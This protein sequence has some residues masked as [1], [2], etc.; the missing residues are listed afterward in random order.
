MVGSSQRLIKVRDLLEQA[1]ETIDALDDT[2]LGALIDTALQDVNAKIKA[3][4]A[5]E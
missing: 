5:N 4:E 2:F 1:L 3:A